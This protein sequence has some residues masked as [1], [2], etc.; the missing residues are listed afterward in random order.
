MSEVIDSKIVELKFNNA[1]FEKNVKTSL[2]TIEKLKKSL[3]FDT[4]T[5]SV[6]LLQNALQL[7]GLKNINTQLGQ[8]VNTVDKSVSPLM[9]TITGI[10]NA[11]TNTIGGAI[12]GVV[13]QIKAGGI[14]RAMNI[15]QAKF[16]LQGIGIKWEDIGQSINDA[17]SGTAYGL[18]QAAKVA[19]TLSAS[20]ISLDVIGKD[21]VDTTDDLTEMEMVL[22]GISG[23]AAQTNQDFDSVAHVFSTVAGNGRLMGMQ[24]TQL[25]TYGMNAAA[26]L[27][28]ELGK[29]ESEIR[30]MASKGQISAKQFF[31]TMYKLYWKN[32][33]KA[34]E[35]LNGVTSNIKSAYGRIG[36]AFYSP[37]IEN[38]GPIVHMLNAYK[39]V[40]GTVATYLK[41]L[42]TKDSKGNDISGRLVKFVSY[43]LI[44]D[45]KLVTDFLAKINENGDVVKAWRA[46]YRVLKSGF[47]IFQAT[48]NFIQSIGIAFKKAFPE[49]IL[50]AWIDINTK[51]FNFVNIFYF[52]SK[53]IKKN[54]KI[55]TKSFKGIRGV[56]EPLYENVKN[57]AGGF[58]MFFD[59][60]FGGLNPLKEFS[61]FIQ[62]ICGYLHVGV[63]ETEDWYSG[64]KSIWKIVEL[65]YSVFSAFGQAIYE[66]FKEGNFH[67]VKYL[68]ELLDIL[69]SGIVSNGKKT[70]QLK[71]TFKIFTTAIGAIIKILGLALKIF[72]QLV[73]WGLKLGGVLLYITSPIGTLVS[74]VFELATGFGEALKNIDL[75]K[76][77][78]L[79]KFINGIKDAFGKAKDKLK[80][81]ADKIHD[82]ATTEIGNIE[83]DWPAAFDG[84]LGALD[85]I[86]EKAGKVKNKI[87]NGV[88][89][90]LDELKTRIDKAF[91]KDTQSNM[92]DSETILERIS[93]IDILGGLG[94]GLQVIGGV[95]KDI[96]DKLKDSK[97]LSAIG[98]DLGEFIKEISSALGES[99]NNDNALEGI[100]KI[101]ETIGKI[102]GI[103]SVTIGKILQSITDNILAYG[104]SAEVSK[105][106]DEFVNALTA[107][108]LLNWSSAAAQ[109]VSALK[110]GP[111]L[112]KYFN[113]LSTVIRDM[114]KAMLEI[115]I[116]L[117]IINTISD[118][119]NF[120]KSV[121]VLA[122]F[123]AA[124][125]II[126]VM[127]MGKANSRIGGWHFDFKKKE[128]S[129]PVFQIA[130]MLPI[131]IALGILMIAVAAALRMV[132]GI[133]DIIPKAIALGI[134]VAVIAAL[135]VFISKQTPALTSSQK[136]FMKVGPVIKS[137]AVAM[138][139]VAAAIWV[140]GQLPQDKLTAGVNAMTQM[141][142][143]ITL[144]IFVLTALLRSFG[145]TKGG[146]FS[147]Y[148]EA[149]NKG[150][151]G[152]L[153]GL[154]A[155]MLSIAVVMI[156]L[157]KA[158]AII[159]IIPEKQLDKGVSK[160]SLMFIVIG[161]LIAS[162][163][164]IANYTSG[165]YGNGAA[166]L[167]AA[168][169]A[170]IAIAIACQVLAVAMGAF[171]LIP[172]KAIGKGLTV[173][174]SAL[175][176]LVVAA[177]VIQYTGA[178][179]ALLAL[180][181]VLVSIGAVALLIAASVW[182]LTKAFIALGEA[183]PA[184]VAGAAVFFYA[185]GKGIGDF[186]KGIADVIDSILE[187]IWVCI[188]AIGEFLVDK[189][190]II[191]QWLIDRAVDLI[192]FIAPQLLPALNSGLKLI[193]KGLGSVLFGSE[194]VYEPYKG[195]ISN[196]LK[197]E[198]TDAYEELHKDREN[199]LKDM[200]VKDND[201]QYY[202]DAWEKLQG[203]TN[204][205][206]KIKKGYEEQAETILNELNEA[207]GTT[208]ELDE[209]HTLNLKKA[210]KQIEK[211]ISLKRAESYLDVYKDDYTK[212][213]KDQ[214]ELTKKYTEAKEAYD[215]TNDDLKTVKDQVIELS[216][217]D[218]NPDENG[219]Y[220]AE[221]IQKMADTLKLIDPDKYTQDYLD[222]MWSDIPQMV[223]AETDALK[224]RQKE[225]AKTRAEEQKTVDDAAELL[226]SS[227]TLT[228][229]Y[230]ELE[231]AIASGNYKA[232]EEMAFKI[233]YNF[234]VAENATESSLKRQTQA[235]KDELDRINKVLKDDPH[236]ELFLQKQQDYLKLI[237][238]SGE[239]ELR[240]K[241]NNYK[242]VDEIDAEQEKKEE[243]KEAKADAK[244]SKKKKKK[245]KQAKETVEAQAEGA[246]EA[247]TD[248]GTNMGINV[249]NALTDELKNSDLE[250]VLQGDVLSQLNSD[251]NKDYAFNAMGDVGSFS[252]D[253]L[254]SGMKDY[255]IS[256]S[257][258]DV[259]DTVKGEF[260]SD[261]MI[262]SPSKLMMPIGSSVVEG[263]AVGIGKA[264]SYLS[265][266][267][268]KVKNAVTSAF[269]NLAMD[270]DYQPTITPV[271]DLSN[272]NSAAGSINGLF[273]SR[274]FALNS[275][276]GSISSSMREIQN[277]DKN[278]GLIAA[279]NRLNGTT[280]NNVYNVN[281]ITYDDG[282][283]IAD[284]VGQ[285]INAAMVERRM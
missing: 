65:V 17:V 172:W 61:K 42:G 105:I 14:N 192:N 98:K 220:T 243:Q 166:T 187:S 256:N 56:L 217:I 54:A 270:G 161:L 186:F 96:F 2:T 94:K 144:C 139:I 275:N 78:N 89:K 10:G 184:A 135:A 136:A 267:I 193:A 246:K 124:M 101:A 236:N 122:G 155:V 106:V 283:N 245:K 82:F 116:A 251:S 74:K 22:K 198:V 179:F 5:T 252:M 138:L 272:V 134:G 141:V 151:P 57:L 47:K 15:E 214:E 23:V 60:T 110:G 265:N 208:I 273:A 175:V 209:D 146:N 218:L 194:Y 53:N 239:E 45:I 259:V 100:E 189:G 108:T 64:F 19:A 113:T 8:I 173:M 25:S 255:D 200:A 261:F 92:E 121:K 188:V 230:E 170:I 191:A 32:A 85:N 77:E 129:K 115:A 131:L 31:D 114:A 34:N 269:D 262:N 159:A 171:A 285:L 87:K 167:G 181:G 204:E 253:G 154:A 118:T 235:Y 35:T 71:N 205:N 284:A 219:E 41:P 140:L 160:L 178:T 13:A 90:A 165:A 103:V 162:L 196:A 36:A 202:Q 55:M 51:L 168:A 226:N 126:G 268:E 254:F 21:I 59:E 244:A 153:L 69:T 48:F 137:I 30:E 257:V 68:I 86:I 216:K 49:S 177:V 183:G 231:D 222:A 99:L 84:V 148:T 233:K 29:T 250:N 247:A 81:F 147:D 43:W 224:E 24:L 67:P 9:A 104:S 79:E 26:D 6:N 143:V 281:G 182:L 28:K 40:I 174:A 44:K 280:N 278:A 72:A 249:T 128:I 20:G 228:K 107:V 63:V 102:I 58:K 83:I 112:I 271:V 73:N 158:F 150:I 1:E 97:L 211:A 199:I 152:Q 125:Y 127:L 109:G 240:L 7:K 111:V 207:L 221:R 274:S 241:N 225:I 62:D 119:E 16:S 46:V 242:K 38:N 123:L 277:T 132:N 164:G 33:A 27:G 279:I 11:I 248:T 50:N 3:N 18:D 133:D 260:K 266:P 52:A 232:A 95:F 264:E 195:H 234:K 75:T 163:I 210:N 93:K 130:T 203:M 201:I 282:S 258:Q 91:G 12:S 145:R 176:A 149:G 156:T 227:T 185:I 80:D 37:L 223:Q 276:I 66:T 197:K 39:D 206:G 117:Y 70:N 263:I 212:A 4:V 213:I 229:Q 215:K 157:A 237:E 169:G 180:A 142:I 76:Y 120:D 88:G 190:P 238:M